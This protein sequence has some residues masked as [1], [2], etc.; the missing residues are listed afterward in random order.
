MRWT[1]GELNLLRKMSDHTCG[2]L[3]HLNVFKK[4]HSECAIRRMRERLNLPKGTITV[5]DLKQEPAEMP[6][7]PKMNRAGPVVFDSP[8]YSKR[9]LAHL[10]R[11]FGG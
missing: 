7:K 5:R 9:I 6:V 2:A 8:H 10:N 11:H 3:V 4:R 1:P